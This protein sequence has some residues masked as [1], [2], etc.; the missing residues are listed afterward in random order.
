MVMHV[1]AGEYKL[2]QRIDRTGSTFVE[3]GRVVVLDLGGGA[4]REHWYLYRTIADDVDRSKYDEPTPYRAPR[5]LIGNVEDFTFKWRAP[6]PPPTLFDPT[7]YGDILDKDG[8]T[9][10]RIRTDCDPPDALPVSAPS[11][12]CA[13]PEQD[14][15]P[16]GGPSPWNFQIYLAPAG[17]YEVRQG[18][19]ILPN[20]ITMGVVGVTL[21][22][23]ATDPTLPK[24]VALESWLLYP[25]Y[26]APGASDGAYTIAYRVGT[27][28]SGSGLTQVLAYNT[29]LP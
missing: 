3:V 27:S 18:D 23:P 16:P 10:T 6:A 24:Y 14:R 17:F 13:P 11:P 20:L 1:Q 29:D 8:I 15:E 25:T 28:P 22:P 5:P 21:A 4:T 12:P 7:K 26:A 2:T 19:P 9:H